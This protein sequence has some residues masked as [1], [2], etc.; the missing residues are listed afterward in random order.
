MTRLCAQ[1]DILIERVADAPVSSR[2]I[3]TADTGSAI[4]AAGE[5]TGHHHRIFGSV[6]MY[7]DDALAREI[8]RGLYVAHLRVTTPAARLEHEEDAQLAPIRV[9]HF[10]PVTTGCK[11]PI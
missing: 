3:E 2:V 7:R 8:P 5:E 4:V 9:T 11:H 6:T 10:D 1:G